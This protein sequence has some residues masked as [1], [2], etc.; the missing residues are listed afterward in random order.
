MAKG[1]RVVRKGSIK[2]IVGN[3]KGVKRVT[4]EEERGEEAKQVKKCG[5]FTVVDGGEVSEWSVCCRER[6]QKGS[7]KEKEKSKEVAEVEMKGGGQKIG[8]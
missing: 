7:Y 2:G 4:K 1:W 6:Q 3:R 8:R 5:E